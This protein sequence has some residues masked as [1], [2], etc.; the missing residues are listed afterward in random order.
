MCG[1]QPVLCRPACFLAGS[2]DRR[3]TRRPTPLRRPRCRPARRRWPCCR[4]RTARRSCLVGRSRRSCADQHVL[5]GPATAAACRPTP[6]PASPTAD[7]GRVAVEGHRDGAPWRAVPSRP[8]DQ[9]CL[10]GPHTAAARVDPRRPDALVVAWPPTMA[11]SPSEDSETE[12]SLFTAGSN[13]SR[14]DQLF[15]A[16]SRRRRCACRPTRPH[17]PRLSPGPPTMAVLPS[18]DSETELP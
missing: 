14:A 4:R 13:R 10:L 12:R 6:P 16:G 7:D 17:R 2:R 5:A 1:S 9:L 11:V 18:E 3:C 15:L 8:C